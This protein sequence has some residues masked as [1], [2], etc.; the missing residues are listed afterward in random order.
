MIAINHADDM[1]LM[2]LSSG[3]Q[4]DRCGHTH[5]YIH[6]VIVQVGIAEIQIACVTVN[7]AKRER[8]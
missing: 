8:N 3:I 5:L 2:L 1:F 4:L 6:S 7:R